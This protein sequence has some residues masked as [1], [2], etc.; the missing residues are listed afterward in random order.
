MNQFNT[1]VLLVIF[2]RTDTT[3]LVLK[4]ISEVRPKYIYVAADGPRPDKPGETQSC[5][6]A[7]KLVLDS[8]TWPAEV[9]TLFH[10]QNLGCGKAVSTAVT[11]FFTHVSEGIILEDDTIP[12]PSF[13]N[14]CSQLLEYYRTDDRI[15]H[16]GCA[17]FQPPGKKYAASYYFSS[18]AHGW[19]F[20]TWKRAWDSYSFDIKDLAAFM[21]SGQIRKYY[22]DLKIIE[23]WYNVFRTMEYHGI[24]TWDHQWTLSIW[25]KGGLTIIPAVNMISNIGVGPDA[26]NTKAMGDWFNIPKKELPPVKHPDKMIQDKAADAYTCYH[27]YLPPVPAMPLPSLWQRFKKL[28]K[29]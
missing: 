3:A 22:N 17:N 16:I 5:E 10:D 18:I 11:W 27:Y 24:D 1:P 12:N 29:G 15:M 9:K 25:K 23:Y 4:A 8:I 2:N 19:G 28:L 20:A 13:F 14:Y 6:A 21:A 7:R 26:T